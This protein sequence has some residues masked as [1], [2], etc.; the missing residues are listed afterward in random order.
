M[1]LCSLT[2]VTRQIISGYFSGH[3]NI[4][5]EFIIELLK[6]YSQIFTDWF[7][8]GEVEMEVDKSINR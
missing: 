2:N 5:L 6:T 3:Y 1:R 7:L 8:F 4:P